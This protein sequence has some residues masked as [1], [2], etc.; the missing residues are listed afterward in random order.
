M[1]EWVRMVVSLTLSGSAVA[2]AAVLV[3]YICIRW[4]PKWFL[5]CLWL[6]VLLSFLLPLGSKY[7]LIP[8]P[9]AAQEP[10]LQGQD[11]LLRSADET[12]LPMEQYDRA[13]VAQTGSHP[14]KLSDFYL[15]LWLCGTLIVL[16]WKLAGY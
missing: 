14:V 10:M 11:A 1:N 7:S 15:R 6:S 16:A 8:T 12:I 2:V 9:Q 3:R 4:V 13:S 5:S